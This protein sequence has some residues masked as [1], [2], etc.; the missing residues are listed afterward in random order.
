[1][2]CGYE[3]KV[4]NKKNMPPSRKFYLF[5]KLVKNAKWW[6][7]ANLPLEKVEG[8]HNFSLLKK[9]FLKQSTIV[10]IKCYWY[11]FD[12]VL[13]YI[14]LI[15]TPHKH[16]VAAIL[17]WRVVFILAVPLKRT[18]T[19]QRQLTS[20]GATTHIQW[21]LLLLCCQESEEYPLEVSC[22]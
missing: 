13:I 15:S 12:T 21:L 5:R 6:S 1:M 7:K 19:D 17:T 14:V 18:V 9:D 2:H 20:S 16:Y 11:C 22:C 4:L 10:A 8:L 3:L